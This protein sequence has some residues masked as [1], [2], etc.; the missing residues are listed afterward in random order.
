[1]TRC[2]THVSWVSI[3][4]S[5]LEKEPDAFQ[6][7][8]VT[9]GSYFCLLGNGCVYDC[10]SFPRECQEHLGEAREQCKPEWDPRGCQRVSWPVRAMSIKGRS[11]A[12]TLPELCGGKRGINVSLVSH[13]AFF[14]TDFYFICTCM[15]RSVCRAWSFPSTTGVQGIELWMLNF[16][17]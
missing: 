14:K 11:R 1:M 4:L 2:T 6:E 17:S 3:S 10:S 5:L 7:K 13:P 9:G 15:Q 12:R 16:M 8:G